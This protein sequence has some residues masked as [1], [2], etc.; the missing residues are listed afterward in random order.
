MENGIFGTGILIAVFAVALFV[1]LRTTIKRFGLK[2]KCCGGKKPEKR[3]EKAL[4]FEPIFEIIVRIDGLCCEDCAIRV[5]NA[6]NRMA[7]VSAKACHH[8]KRAV[9]L[10][11]KEPDETKIRTV[12]SD[13]GFAVTE[14]Q[15]KRL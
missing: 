5:E 14:I 9:L 3:E 15:T 10:L 12:V 7:E 2:R 6:F 8:E 11:G 1:A 4:D 13:C